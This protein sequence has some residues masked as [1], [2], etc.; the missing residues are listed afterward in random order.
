MS[1]FELNARKLGELILYL[2]K[3]GADDPAFG[4]TRLYK[5]LFLADFWAYRELGRPITGETYVHRQHGPAPKHFQS[6][7]ADLVRRGKLRVVAVD[8]GGHTQKRPRA[9]SKP[10]TGLFSEPELD[11]IERAANELAGLSAKEVSD[12]SHERPGWKVTRD[13]QQIPYE[14]AFMWYDDPVSHAD[15]EWARTEVDRRANPAR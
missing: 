9:V 10:D 15:I 2:A 8:V 12:W 6:I 1:E 5:E 3:R 7:Q 14:M 13:R 11:I 4:T